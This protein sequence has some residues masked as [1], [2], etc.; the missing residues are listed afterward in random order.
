MSERHPWE[1]S[2]AETLNLLN[3]SRPASLNRRAGRNPTQHV[4]HLSKTDRRGVFRAAVERFRVAHP[5]LH[6][7]QGQLGEETYRR[8]ARTNGGEWAG[9][10]PLCGGRD[11]LRVWP[12]PRDRAPR[13]WCRQCK[14]SG[15]ALAWAVRLS[16][17]NPAERGATASTLRLYDILR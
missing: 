4:Q 11:R 6:L 5:I 14:V 8:V 2:P 10:C 13:A 17:R 12:S 3:T 9:P 16:G 7:L 1:A 15:D